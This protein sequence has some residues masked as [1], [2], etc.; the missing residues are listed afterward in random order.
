MHHAWCRC[1]ALRSTF[2]VSAAD[3][4]CFPDEVADDAEGRRR[5]SSAS[6]LSAL[7]SAGRCHSAG[8]CSARGTGGGGSLLTLADFLEQ[9]PQAQHQ[10]QQQQHA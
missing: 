6:G 8:C 2:F 1:D 9:H 4:G 5:P 3:G 7:A 10:V